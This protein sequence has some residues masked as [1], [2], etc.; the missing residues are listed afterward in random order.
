M[1]AATSN[2]RPST[3]TYRGVGGGAD[4]LQRVAVEHHEVGLLAD[5]ERADLV[6]EPM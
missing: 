2:R 3:I 6:R 4:V 5:L 1:S